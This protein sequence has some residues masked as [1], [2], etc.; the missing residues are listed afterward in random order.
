MALLPNL[1]VKPVVLAGEGMRVGECAIETEMGAVDLGIRP[2]LSEI[3]RGFF[4]RAGKSLPRPGA[5]DK[6]VSTTQESG[7]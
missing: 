7:S 6:P 1:P 5:A 2:Q 3:E 4:D